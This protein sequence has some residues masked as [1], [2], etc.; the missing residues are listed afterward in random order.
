MSPAIIGFR[1]VLVF[2]EALRNLFVFSDS[3]AV[4]LIFFS[5]SSV[6]HP[7]EYLGQLFGEPRW[8]EFFTPDDRVGAM[9]P[10]G[11]R[12]MSSPR[13]FALEDRN[14]VSRECAAE[15]FTQKYQV[16]VLIHLVETLPS[17]LVA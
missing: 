5:F 14:G 6:V 2:G 16:F 9:V 17:S 11:G 12:R 15:A 4:L 13:S 3:S 1:R 10:I 8:P 7:S